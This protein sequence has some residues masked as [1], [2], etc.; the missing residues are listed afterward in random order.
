MS[1]NITTFYVQQYAKILNELVQQHTSRLRRWCTEERYVGQAGSPVEQ[2][3]AVAMQPV[4]QRYGPMQRVDAP[5]S[6]R[7]VYPSDYDLPQLFDN[8][9]KLRLQ[10]DPK[11][12]FVRNAHYA[13]NRQ[14]DDL[15]IAAFSG[16]AAV[17]AA[18]GIATN[19]VALPAGEIVSVQ[20]GATAPTGLTVAKLRQAK[21]ILMQNEAYSDEEGD[22]GDPN[23]GLVCVAGAR[24]LD[25]LMAEAQVISRDFNDQPVL[26]EGRVKRFLGIDF[27]RSERLLTGTDDQAGTSTKV[28]IWQKEGMHLGLWNDITTNISQRH[29]LQSEPWQAYV[30][31]TAGA[32][33]L[34]ETRVTQVWARK[35]QV[36]SQGAGPQLGALKESHGTRHASQHHGQQLR[37]L[38][39]R[40]YF[41][42]HLG[43]Q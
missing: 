17:G 9:D 5:T 27:V 43:V 4:T 37:S 28:H 31:M 3:G 6:R 19:L 13:A 35:S 11:G 24:Q 33:R 7:W 15:I 40:S 16:N 8:F 38:P 23:S 34:E 1:T 22:P 10:I 2:V 21:L 30:F 39:A 29:D 18:G 12:G 20:Q 36:N 42:L 26:E 25:N 14:F 32:T 41:G